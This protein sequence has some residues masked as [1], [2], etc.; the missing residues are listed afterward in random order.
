MCEQKNEHLN[1]R[2][3]KI[4]NT[5]YIVE[6]QFGSADIMELYADYTA[7]KI[8]VNKRTYKNRAPKT[9]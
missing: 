9:A 1:K 3:Y 5:L 7:N 2:S 8:L 4:G 6:S